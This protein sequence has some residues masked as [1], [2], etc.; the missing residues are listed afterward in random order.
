[1]SICGITG[2]CAVTV[3]VHEVGGGERRCRRCTE[4]GGG[5]GGGSHVEGV[6]DLMWRCTKGCQR[7]KLCKRHN[8]SRDR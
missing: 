1:M 2:R 5:A 3:E 7:C 8:S 4:V 6:V